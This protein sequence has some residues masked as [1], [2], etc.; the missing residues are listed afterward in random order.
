MLVTIE[1]V[2]S[3][4]KYT[5]TLPKLSVILPTMKLDGKLLIGNNNNKNFTLDLKTD[6]V[7]QTSLPLL[8]GRLTIINKMPDN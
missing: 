1:L 7:R 5:E 6:F 3:L 2:T 8:D 4:T